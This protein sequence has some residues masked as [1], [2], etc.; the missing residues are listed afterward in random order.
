MKRIILGILFL[1]FGVN[2]LFSQSDD[3]QINVAV[4]NF[5]NQTGSNGLGYLSS[6]LADSLSAIPFYSV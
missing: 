3:K 2:G 6:S 1:I 4:I 5:E